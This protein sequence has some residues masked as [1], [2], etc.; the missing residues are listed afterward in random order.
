MYTQKFYVSNQMR[1]RIFRQQA[2][3]PALA[4]TPLVEQHDAIKLGIKKSA[5]HRPR[6]ASRSSMDEDDRESFR[7]PAF[8]EVDLMTTPDLQK[9]V[10]IWFQRWI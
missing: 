1:S 8:F 9:P 6:L 3:G 7:I 5:M 2:F 10:A 4:T